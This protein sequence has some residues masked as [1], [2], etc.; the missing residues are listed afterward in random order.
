MLQLLNSSKSLYLYCTI[1]KNSLSWG[2]VVALVATTLAVANPAQAIGFSSPVGLYA[3]PDDDATGVSVSINISGQGNI[4][5]FDSVTITGFTHPFYPDLRA[6]LTN[7]S[8][9]VRLFR[10][11][12]APDNQVFIR[13]SLVLNGNYTFATA[14]AN[15]YTQTVTP[16]PT[17]TTYASFQPL[18]AFNGQSLNGNWTLNVQD[19]ASGDRGSFTQFTINAT[20]VPFEFEPTGGVVLLGGAWLLRKRLI[21]KG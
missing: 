17:A 4:I 15:W 19:R 21:K 11:T 20:P 3:I 5:S 18:T 16:V 6:S 7:G 9:T 8:S 14:G 1:L 13:Q 2:G 10:T 12:F